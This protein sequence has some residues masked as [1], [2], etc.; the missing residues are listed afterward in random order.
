MINYN[1]FSDLIEYIPVG[2][3]VHGPQSEI[4]Y[5]N[6]RA[7]EI[8]GLST[9]QMLGKVDI[10]PAWRFDFPDGTPMSLADYPVNRVLKCKEGVWG[11]ILKVHRPVAK[12]VAWVLC[13]AFPSI[14]EDGE[15]L[16]VITC[17]TDISALKH[18]EEA[19]KAS[20][21]RL[22]LMLQGANDAA[23]DWDLR[24]HTVYYSPRWWQMIGREP[25]ELEPTE[26]LWV[27]LLH[28]DDYQKVMDKM[29]GLFDRSGP[30]S[31]DTEF[32]LQTKSGSYLPVLCRGVI[33]RGAD[34]TPLRMSGTNMDLTERKESEARIY[35]LAYYDVLTGLANRT[36]LMER[37][38]A[39]IALCE[40][41]KQIGALLIID[42]DNFKILN[43]TM[44]HD[45]GD[46]LLKMVAD[47]LLQAV[48][49]CELVARLGGDEFVIVMEN[50]GIDER[51]AALK[52][53]S[54]GQKVRG[55]LN[56]PFML[57]GKQ[58]RT[59][60][61]IG[62]ALFAEGRPG[63]EELLKQADVAMYQAKEAGKNALRFFDPAM[64]AAV[65]ERVALENDL[66]NGVLENEFRLFCQP[67]VDAC[68]R[69]CGG[70]VLIRWQHP[71]R[72]L[73]MPNQFIPL[74]EQT[75]L[76]IPIGEWVLRKTCE[77]LV[78]WESHPSL[79][80]ISL[81]VNV[82]VNQVR[83]HNFVERV[84]AIID[85]CGA[86]PARIMLELTESLMA[87][88]VEEIILKMNAL[89]VRGVRFSVDDFGTG[90]SSL[91]YLK[92]FPLS[93]LKID[94]SFVREIA[95]NQ[96]DAVI[97]EIIITLAKKLGLGVLA[98]GVE[99]EDQLNFL[100]AHDCSYFQGYLFGKPCA[101]ELFASSFMDLMEPVSRHIRQG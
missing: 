15:V 37:L 7:S 14:G 25:D 94:Q 60:P 6:D 54:V 81:S 56:D 80:Q 57:A 10:D 64:Q 61:S 13:N 36:L 38:K 59:S 22:N 55:L 46:A 45:V 39:A 99:T 3:V 98:E 65:E 95:L 90:Y 97:T 23:W 21:E 66:R 32:R 67:Q 30:S 51:G 76:I 52:A 11:M 49:R 8:L 28:P 16:Q 92:R 83:D 9:A 20:E 44:G 75:D 74:A 34:G 84:L 47:R 89:R 48:R 26:D 2:I 33:L 24:Q 96:H 68:G 5:A 82:S 35:Q 53:K 87:E 93:E 71:V 101:I 72:G 29:N 40:R 31:F 62:I 85:D 41:S 78:E 69:L 77:T 70:E 42:L 1:L 18:A 91:S 79:A 50:L 27:K 43:D 100:L 63:L 12:D 86:N 73:V 17:F 58:L 19:L 88:N 4:L